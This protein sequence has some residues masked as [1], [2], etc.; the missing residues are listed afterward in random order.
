[1]DSRNELHDKMMEFIDH[2]KS[3]A[4]EQFDNLVDCPILGLV[5]LLEEAFYDYTNETNEN[6]SPMTWGQVFYALTETEGEEI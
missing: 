2:F 4:E 3:S 5:H 6:G 1:M